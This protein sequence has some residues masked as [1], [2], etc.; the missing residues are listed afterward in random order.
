MRCLSPIMMYDTG[1][2]TASGKRLLSPKANPRLPFEQAAIPVPC[3]KCDA[4]R[5]NLQREWISRLR[6]EKFASDSATF[7]TL[8]YRKN[9]FGFVKEHIQQFVKRLRNVGRDYGIPLDC[10]RYIFTGERGS[11]TGRPHWHGILFGLD[12]LSD[13][14]SPYVAL[15]K[16]GYPVYSSKLLERIWSLGFVSFDKVT[17]KSIRYVSKYILKDGSISLKSQGLGRSPF[18]SVSRKSRKSVYRLRPLFRQ[19][20][21]DG[22][23]YLPSDGHFSPVGL[24]KSFDRYL[25]RCDS[26]LYEFVKSRRSHYVSNLPFGD[27]GVCECSDIARFNY[28]RNNKKG[29]LDEN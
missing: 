29:I 12:C 15:F 4:C 18:V 17:D 13:C 23:I 24:P 1:R 10:L 7:I 2:T 27:Y 3:G 5:L 26:V 21:S 8:T 22:V 25:E 14:W 16:D 20:C 9:P 28:S 11:R 19:V 6:L